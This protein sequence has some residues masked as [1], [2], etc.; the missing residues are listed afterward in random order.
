MSLKAEI[1]SPLTPADKM[2]VSQHHPHNAGK[3]DVWFFLGDFES[4]SDLFLD[5]ESSL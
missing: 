2:E 4:A 3:A 1:P 5:L